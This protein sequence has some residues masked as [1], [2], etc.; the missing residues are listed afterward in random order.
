MEVILSL[1]MSEYRDG[2]VNVKFLGQE[3]FVLFQKPGI[4]IFSKKSLKMGRHAVPQMGCAC[5]LSP[6]R[7]DQT[8]NEQH[9]QFVS[10]AH[11]NV[12]ILM[13]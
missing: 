1:Q 10:W 12:W 11:A 13:K 7:A 8:I 9:V 2:R 4:I 6:D 3:N 5:N